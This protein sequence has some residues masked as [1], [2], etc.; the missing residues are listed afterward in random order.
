MK[1]VRRHAPLKQLSTATYIDGALA[2]ICWTPRTAENIRESVEHHIHSFYE[3]L[4]VESGHGSHL[5][6]GEPVAAGPGHL[7]L[8]APGSA[9]NPVGLE[10]T[11][12]WVLVFNPQV[13]DAHG[14]AGAIHGTRSRTLGAAQALLRSLHRGEQRHLLLQIP[15]GGRPALSR[16]FRRIED[17]NGGRQPGWDQ[18]IKAQLN[19]ILVDLLR[20]HTRRDVLPAEAAHPSVAQAMDFID[21]HFGRPIG[22]RDIARHVGR[23]PAHLTN[24]VKRHTG[25]SAMAWLSDRRL[26]EARNLLLTSRQS[27]RQIAAELG[28]QSPRHFSFMFRRRYGDA[29]TRWRNRISG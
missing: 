9:H 11:A 1:A 23:S 10:G 16:L 22:L 3:I 18:A 12:V 7:A 21:T 19:L 20:R 14:W 8:F 13:L 5:I 28:Y 29:P 26:V 24:L 25:Q 15:A 4:F 17:E 6:D 27:V 2:N